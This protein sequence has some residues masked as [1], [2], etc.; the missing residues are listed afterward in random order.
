MRVS[1]VYFFLAGIVLVHGNGYGQQQAAAQGQAAGQQ[2]INIDA[3][4]KFHFGNAADPARDFNYSL[5]TLF[6]K[7]GAGHRT[8][9][10]PSFNDSSWRTLDLPHDWA[11]ELPFVNIPN[12]DL[13]SHG[14]K[15]VGGL[16]Q[17]TSIGWY[18]KHFTVPGTDSGAR[19]Q[20][21]FDGVFRNASFWLNGFYLGNNLSGYVGVGYDVTDYLRYDGDNVLVV[22]VDATQYEGWFYEGAGIYRHV[23]LNKYNNVHIPDG[24][25]YA[26]ANLDL[27]PAQGKG[28]FALLTVETTV[29]NKGG[30][31][32]HCSV[33]S[34]L[35]DREGRPVAHHDPAVVNL[36]VNGR[37][38]F[39]LDL[40]VPNPRRWS[41]ED[42]YLYRVVSVVR[43]GGRVVDTIKQ[44]FGFRSLRF[45]ANEGF[46]LNGQHLKILGT[47]NHQDHA[48]VGS[49]L[50]D[51][52]QYYRIRLL[53]ELGAN[54]YRTS[55]NAPTPELLDACDSLGML[56]LD[57]NRLL[58]S[59]PEYMDQF[60][61]LILRDRNHPSVFLWS[62]GNEEQG[63]QTN[64][65]GRRIAQTLLAK[66]RELD[67]GRTST[68][69]ADVPN[70]FKGINEVIPIRGFNYRQ[71][72][73]A[74]Y[75]RDHPG[76]PIVGTEMGSTVT[77]RGIYERDSVRG[78]VP[79]EDMTAP[80]WASKARDW[81]V[82]AA[83]NPYW[84]GGFVWTGFDYRGE[85]TPFQWPNINSHFGIMDM[86]GIPK[87]LYY[88]YQSWWTDKDVLHI[89]PH[90]NWRDKRGKPV[91][92]WV[93]TN[94]ADA[95]LFLNGKS[96][97]KKDMPR[98]GH[99]QWTV[100]YEPGVLEAVANKGGRRLTARVETTGPPA[101]VVLTPY[102]TT[103]LADGRDV[104]VINV[105][106]VDREGREVPDADNM[107]R[108]IISGNGHI[109]GVGNGDPSCHEPD[110]CEDGAWQ[111]SL[112]NGKCQVL[113][114][115]GKGS[116][117]IRFEAKAANLFTGSTDIVTV[118]P[119]SLDVMDIDPAYALK[120]EA[121]RPR[122]AGKMLGADISFLPQL[123]ARGM[124]FS[125]KGVE[126]DP[127]LI[128][129]DHGFNTVRLRIFNDPGLDSGYSPGK[130]FCDLEH[131]K[132]MAKRVKAAGMRLL[133]DLHYSDTWADPGKQFKPAAW[134]G[135]TFAAL[136]KALFDYTQGVIGALKE[137]GT[138]PDM[139]QVGNEINHGLVWPEGSIS[140]LDSLSQLL[141]AGIAAVKSVDPSIVIM[142]HIALGGQHDESAF[143]IDQM[144]ARGVHFDVIGES[145]YPKWHGTTD[146]L[147]NNLTE[148]T[149]R[150]GKD[151][152]VVEYS[153]RKQ[154]VNAI[155]FGLPGGKGK[156]TC[157]WEPL[158]T[159]ESLFDRDGKSNE[160]L[161]MY[162]EI[163]AAY[164]GGK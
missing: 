65:F 46:F 44:R 39:T 26:H 160:F 55:H 152:I 97:G 147:R 13:M 93:N 108:F 112:F 6:A 10:D 164:L 163:S 131:T 52:L 41:V 98:N 153:G 111:R 71:F 136:K 141:S 119:G 40:S 86:C 135:M 137:Q 1:Q 145:Y 132:A 88:Y 57:E 151:V 109:I 53:K 146:D 12:F 36:D 33:Y 99:L 77:T 107:I 102:K 103:I 17:E 124:K 138:T 20:I 32:A 150:Y 75:H 48:G 159:W 154:E 82:L 90:W 76:Q 2:R 38:T 148:L 7:T 51:Y 27:S 49:A 56:V 34:Y 130:A 63:V 54:A 94:A 105:S 61:R 80:P 22:R 15:P 45:D 70:V 29:E 68:Y 144:L 121:A 156:G 92:V 60:E 113:V 66:Q 117:A 128:L 30:Q 125:D 120:G 3:D 28:G 21:R 74:D 64:S 59:S 115:S 81:W 69:A 85:P 24:G 50:P 106:V 162:D 5:V 139:V 58:N 127:I 140:N 47:N 19:F 91:D 114:Q 67:P 95:E 35:T 78:Y 14:Y 42:P 123:E 84:I 126:K 79:D 89:S 110:K 104:A 158:N 37:A 87:N 129:K 134:R 8:A 25:F 161:K 72:A 62:I 122:E 143:F 157:I 83:E 96:L 118:P 16:F 11:V 73:A 43:S 101:E 142:L 23:W 116:G 18:R 31:R 100:N 9:I 149:Q 4:W 155:A 133:L